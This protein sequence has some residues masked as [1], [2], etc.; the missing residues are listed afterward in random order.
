MEDF[1]NVLKVKDF[2][3]ILKALPRAGKQEVELGKARGRYLA[4]DIISSEDLPATN[5][6]SMDGYAVRSRDTFGASEA[7]P[8]Y[9]EISGQVA[10]DEV[11]QDRLEPGL[12]VR[13]VTGSTLPPGADSV[14]MVEHAH[15]MGGQTVEIRKPVA[16]WENVMLKGE[17][18]TSGSIALRAGMKVSAPRAGI[19]AALGKEKVDVGVVPRVGIISTGD[20]LVPINQTPAPGYIRDVN[21]Y[22]LAQVA[23]EEGCEVNIYGIVPDLENEVQASLVR[24]LDENDVVLVSG[25]S[26]VGNRD[27]TLESLS[28]IEGMEIIV[29]GLALSPGKPTIFARK[30]NKYVWG[31]PGQVTSAQIVMLVLV[32]PL[33][34]HLQ[35]KSDSFDLKKE[36]F[37]RANLSRN[38]A[39][40]YGREDYVRVRLQKDDGRITAVPVPGK[41]GLLKTLLEADGIIRIA[42]N[43]EG[44][45]QDDEVMVRLI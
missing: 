32:I 34:R 16:P 44:L 30:G 12:C 19:L 22:T 8:V 31:L 41:S 39:S 1:F 15:E 6:S 33:L 25:G 42:E 24:A 10:I 17:D 26:S 29:H 20:E 21:S 45:S 37:L 2:I 36:F 18:I 7:N 4:E 43:C 38:I 3:T 9:L 14:V 23:E 28:G 40:K 13:I 27:F 11:P 5:R 35:G